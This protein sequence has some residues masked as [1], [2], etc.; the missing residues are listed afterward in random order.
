MTHS[1]RIAARLL[2][3]TC[4]VLNLPALASASEQARYII[5]HMANTRPAIDWAVTQGANGVEMDLRF[6]EFGKATE[7]RHGGICDCF[8]APGPSSICSVLAT[9]HPE[10]SRRP[11]EASESPARLLRHLGGRSEVALAII[12][13][14]VE[15]LSAAAL[16]TAGRQVVQIIETHLFGAG[17]TG[18]VIISTAKMTSAEFLRSATQASGG[19]RFADR[20]FFSFDQESNKTTEVLANLRDLPSRARAFGTGISACLPGD[21]RKGIRAA[22]SN[23]TRGA[24]SFVYIWTLDSSRSMQKYLDAGAQ[25]VITNYPKR[26]RGVI[27][28]SGRKVAARGALFPL[29]TNDRI[30]TDPE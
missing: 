13:S 3:V 17:Y 24:A 26:L 4:A 22:E 10:G 16:V 30:A 2:I 18:N 8:C 15:K 19:K 9:S 1:S 14:K 7:F 28:A 11:C 29:T 6:D 20:I 5:T 25:G 23:R 21:F 12:D 27:E